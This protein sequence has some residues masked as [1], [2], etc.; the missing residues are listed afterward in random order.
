[1]MF[2]VRDGLSEGCRRAG[3]RQKGIVPEIRSDCSSCA[4]VCGAKQTV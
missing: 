4:G 3:S 2:E 1:M